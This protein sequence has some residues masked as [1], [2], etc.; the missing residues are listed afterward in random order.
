MLS[1]FVLLAVAVSMLAVPA[2]ARAEGYVAPGVGIAFGNPSA[3]G[4]ADF[5]LDVGWLSPEPVGLELD[6]TYAPSFFGGQGPYG[7]NSVST[8]MGNVLVA[9]SGAGPYGSYR[10]HSA[11]AYLS[12]GLGLIREDTTSPAISRNDLGANFGVGAMA[13][14]SG[15]IGVRG[16]IRYFR[17]LVGTATGNTT[18]IDFGSFHF[19][20][21]SI[22]VLFRF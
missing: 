10:G 8:I 14:A 13:I 4:L 11:R 22:S 5:V 17:D 12:G 9:T 15:Q 7:A 21:A 2:A 1:R 6:A 16:D 3:Q 18:N 20:R 19:W